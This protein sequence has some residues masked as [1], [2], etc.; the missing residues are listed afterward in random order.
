MKKN[1]LF[2][3]LFL[4]AIISAQ[5]QYYN[6]LDWTK[7]GLELK[8]ELA[9]K[10]ITAHTNILSYGWDAIKATDVNPENSGEVLLIY[11]YSQSGTTARTRGINDNSGDQGDWNREHT[12]AKSLGN[13]N[14]GTSGP[15][16]DTHHLRAS[17]VSYNS[18]RGS[19]KFADGSG[20]S[21][22]VSGGWFPGDEWKGDIAR[23]MMYMYIRYGDQCKPTG[24]GI[25]NNANA[26]DAMI[27]LFLEWNVEDPVSDFERQ[28]NEYHD[29]NATYAQGNRNPFIDNAYLATRI[30]G[31]ENAIDSWGIF[32]TSD[33]QAPTV[34]TNVA[35]SN[36][37]TSSIDVSWTASADNIA[38][39]KYEVYVDGTLNGEVSNT[40]YTITGLTPNTTYTVTVLAKDIASNKSAQSTAVNGT[41]LADLE[42]PSV[43]TNVTITNEAGTSFKVN[44]SASTDDTAVAGYDVF[45]D[46]T[47]NG[48]TTE[49]NYSFSNLTASTTYSVTVL[50]KDTT[51]NK[52]AQSTAVNAT[53]TDGSAITNEIFFSEYLEGSSNNKAIEI[54]NFTGQIV[55]LKEYS[56]KLGSN[57]QDFGTQTL[58]FTNESIADGDVFVIGNSQL[59][60]CASEVDISSNV[61]Y[62]N[63]N[64][65]LG[66][67][68]NG[69]LIDIIGEE[70]SSTTFGENVTL[71][72]K[73]SIISPNP[74][75]NPN[76]WVE[77]STDDCLDLGKHTISTANVN[78]SEFENF[79][80]YPNPL[81][82]NKLYF[83]VSDNVNIEIYSVLGKLIQFSKI[84]ESKK[85]MDVSNLATGIYLVKISNGNQFVTKKLMKN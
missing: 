30:W 66:L 78:S 48:T 38:V 7:S 26:G 39:T 57:G 63:G 9:T 31:G 29:S 67:F 47:Y 34:P 12:Y 75:Y 55:S 72:R 37:T 50:A 18:Q 65:V 76:E 44:W 11:G 81:N 16:A 49:T 70:N 6:G 19:L 53:T 4:T 84:T 45:L 20:N 41:T 42:A 43:P 74:V 14:L 52:S 13:P 56:V 51:D 2:L 22:S 1:L 46:G 23:M 62:F 10:T 64:D 17:D 80:M 15:G 85:D 59:E 83:N 61:T 68:K 24:V 3:L 69:I 8:E 71:K 5:E 21:G 33:D 73:P 35:L 28:R 77:T 27:D 79:K 82:G 40:N 58:T 25:G 32:I 60:V 54:A 36:I